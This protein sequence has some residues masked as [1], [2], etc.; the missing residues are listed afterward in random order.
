MIRATVLLL[1]TG[2][3]AADS[4]FAECAGRHERVCVHANHDGPII[5]GKVLSPLYAENATSGDAYLWRV[6]VERSFRGSL[7]GTI[8]VYIGSA[9]LGSPAS[10]AI[11]G[12][13]LLLYL[14]PNSSPARETDL[15]VTLGCGYSTRLGSAAEGELA[16]LNRL[17]RRPADGHIFGRV[18]QYRTHPEPPT[19]FGGV[20]VIA[21]SGKRSYPAKTGA[22]G[23]FDVGGLP[24]GTYRLTA[25]YPG[26]EE[27]FPIPILP[28]GCADVDIL[29]RARS[30]SSARSPTAGTPASRF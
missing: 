25:E 17:S 6:Q 16:L 22:D 2:F 9:D 3:V 13:T 18:L 20:R 12:E 11:A 19:V 10:A 1:L 29:V 5:V 23:S 24:P 21:T 4:A 26:A 30:G 27:D 8:V 7:K 15:G 28:H 14:Y